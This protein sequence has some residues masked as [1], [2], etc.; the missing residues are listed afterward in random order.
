MLQLCTDARGSDSW[1]AG[2]GW[3]HMSC[4]DG[5]ILRS[6]VLPEVSS[7]LTLSRVL[8]TPRRPPDGP[9]CSSASISFALH[10]AR[11]ILAA[12]DRPS[13]GSQWRSTVPSFTVR[14]FHWAQYPSTWGSGRGY[15]SIPGA[16]QSPL[17]LD[18]TSCFSA[19]TSLWR[20]GQIRMQLRPQ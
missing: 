5:T 1:F 14:D 12:L 18:P 9:P 16:V 20:L 3:L 7:T 2:L 17:M 13:A 10:Q 19:D 6:H 11:T 15:L 4:S 8:L